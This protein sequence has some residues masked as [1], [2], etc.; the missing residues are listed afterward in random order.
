MKK[1]RLIGFIL[2]IFLGLSA[3]LV[4]GWMVRPAQ[5]VNTSLPSLRSDYK[6]DY[7]LMVAESYPKTEQLPYAVEALRQ[8]NQA[9]PLKAVDQ[10]LLDAQKLGYSDTDLH[11][12]ANLEIRVRAYGGAQ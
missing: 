11:T 7:V 8:L 1:R 9:N 10:A 5:P 4:Y 3:A 12:I 2:A 6:T